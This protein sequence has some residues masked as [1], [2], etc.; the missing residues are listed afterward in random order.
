MKTILSILITS[1]CLSAFGATADTQ[2][3]TVTLPYSELLGL[4]ERAKPEEEKEAEAP[5][6]P[7]VDV[8]V[9]SAVYMID[10]TRQD[11]NQQ[12]STTNQ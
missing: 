2:Q 9:Q 6:K 8:L 5:P 7:P 4:L 1:V 10:C 3:A 11:L 12:P